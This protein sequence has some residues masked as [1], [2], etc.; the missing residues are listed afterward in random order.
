MQTLATTIVEPAKLSM[1]YA[2]KL[3]EGIKPDQFARLAPGNAGPIASNHPAFVYGHLSLYA[4]RIIADLGGDASAV[5]PSEKFMDVFKNGA[6]CVDDAEGTV[7]PAMEVI[8][9]RFF[10]GYEA[11]IE[12]AAKADDATYAAANPNETMRSRFSTM[13]AMHAF[14]LSG[15]MMIHFGQVSSW[16]RACGLGPA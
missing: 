13:A 7:Y 14:Y 15:H 6:E 5:Q 2:R 3:L 11:A 9:E 4:C 10:S 1:G 8:T 16:R 12:A